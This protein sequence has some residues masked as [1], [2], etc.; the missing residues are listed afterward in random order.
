[1]KKIFLIIIFAAI[2][3]AGAYV[4]V[5]GRDNALTAPD[6]K[7]TNN[8]SASATDVVLI[9]PLPY[10]EVPHSFTV[11]GAARGTWYFEASFPIE[12][13]TLDGEVLT[14]IV[15]QAEGEWMTEDFV[16]FSTT[17]IVPASVSGQHV[18]VLK[19]DNPSGLP[20]HDKSLEVPII[21]Q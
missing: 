7:N 4:F 21:I 1:M 15:A 8:N 13:R 9:S 18:L 5:V 2:F 17:I 11:Q 20:E 16:P 10:M 3:S 14:T 19:K 6:L 12:L